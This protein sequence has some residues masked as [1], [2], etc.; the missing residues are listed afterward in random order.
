M[1][2]PEQFFGENHIALATFR[3]VRGALEAGFPDVEVRVSKSQVAFRLGR[4]FAY[5]WTPAQYVRG[6]TA[7][8]VLSIALTDRLDSPRFKEV[9][10]PGPWIHHLE[11][12]D[13]ASIDDEVRGWLNRAATAAADD[14]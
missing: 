8:V 1:T 4:G 2:T 6:A 14:R 3:A 5:L 13:A 11:V 7:P 10:H 12:R 9:V